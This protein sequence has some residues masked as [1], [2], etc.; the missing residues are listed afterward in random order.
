MS[1]WDN[2]SLPDLLQR[3]KTQNTA[4]QHSGLWQKRTAMLSHGL[5]SL[6][7]CLFIQT[8]KSRT[9]IQVTSTHYSYFYNKLITRN[10]TEQRRQSWATLQLAT[11]YTIDLHAVTWNTAKE[12]QSLATLLQMITGANILM[13][14]SCWYIE[15][16]SFSTKQSKETSVKQLSWSL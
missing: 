4:T 5:Q 3:N 7:L 15:H 11:N 13:W 2:H 14:L 12:R 1:I 9:I 6:S 8:T 16:L 10:K